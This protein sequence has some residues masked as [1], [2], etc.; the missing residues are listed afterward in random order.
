MSGH[1]DILA[2]EY[3]IKSKPTQLKNEN[4]ISRSF[5][6]LAIT[7]KEGNTGILSDFAA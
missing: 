5:T 6:L 3:C 1:E 7:A 2:L 4:S